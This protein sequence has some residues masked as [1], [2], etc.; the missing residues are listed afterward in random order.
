MQQDV[1]AQNH[2]E[3]NQSPQQAVRRKPDFRTC[4]QQVPEHQTRQAEDHQR[5]QAARRA[6]F[7]K[8]KHDRKVSA[9]S[10]QLFSG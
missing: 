4:A 2:E 7:E 5:D 1:A 6:A 8:E 10:D 3:Q 9:I